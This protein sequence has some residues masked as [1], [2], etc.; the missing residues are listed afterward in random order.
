[1]QFMA[2]A[3]VN[4]SNMN[5]HAKINTLQW[6]VSLKVAAFHSAGSM[7]NLANAAPKGSR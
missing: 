6:P 4:L 5:M 7:L 1:M 2:P 3:S